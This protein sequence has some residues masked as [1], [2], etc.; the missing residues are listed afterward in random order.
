[1]PH[2]TSFPPALDPS[3]SLDLPTL[4]ISYRVQTLIGMSYWTWHLYGCPVCSL[5]QFF[6][7]FCVVYVCGAYMW[8]YWSCAYAHPCGT[9][10]QADTSILLPWDTLLSWSSP[11]VT[12]QQALR[13]C[14]SPPA[15]GQAVRL[16]LCCYIVLMLEFWLRSS[17]LWKSVLP[18]W[19]ISLAPLYF[20]LWPGWRHIY[21]FINQ[22]FGLFPLW[23]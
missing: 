22:S 3:V 17:W 2:P 8:V 16:T 23:S 4:H 11:L 20:S 18:Q 15:G 19:A 12:G 14:L 1:M 21:P 6:L 5:Y 9:Q 13:T 7:S 10:S